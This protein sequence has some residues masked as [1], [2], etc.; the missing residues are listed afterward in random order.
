M[1]VAGEAYV[2]MTLNG[3]TKD[4]R[5]IISKEM[6]EDMLIS[7]TDLKTFKVIPQGFPFS[8]VNCCNIEEKSKVVLDDF[9][10]VATDS[11]NITP[12]VT[13]KGM[14]INLTK[15]ATPKRVS[16]ARRIPLRYTDPAKAVI[17][18]LIKKNVITRV[19]KP[20]AWCSPAFFVPKP[21]GKVRLVT[22]YTHLNKF[23]KRPV[24]PFPSTRDILQAI[25]STAKIFAK[26]DAVH[27]YFQLGLDEESSYITTFL[28]PEGRFRY[29]RAPMG[30]NASSDEWCFHSD[31]LI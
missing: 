15:S 9:D 28:I 24:H 12:M 4:I 29:L 2:T 5:V 16:I 17:E 20:T 6:K 21:G 13:E 14:K 31:M 1:D 18:D 22:D 11:L 7:R 25:P 23:V 19:H 26:L 27:G 3:I 8:I 30:L 10:D